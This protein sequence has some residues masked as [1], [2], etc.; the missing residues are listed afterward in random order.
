[1]FSF[2]NHYFGESENKRGKVTKV[3][4]FKIWQMNREIKIA[5]PE[6][7]IFLVKIESAKMTYIAEVMSL[8]PKN[9]RMTVFQFFCW[10]DFDYRSNKVASEKNRVTLFSFWKDAFMVLMAYLR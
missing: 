7:L 2:T 1:M 6:I 5:S 4:D 9:S 8:P 3:S 10:D